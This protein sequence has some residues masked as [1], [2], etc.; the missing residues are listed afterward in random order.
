MKVDSVA[1]QLNS[2]KNVVDGLATDLDQAKHDIDRLKPA[3]AELSG[4][5]VVLESRA[6]TNLARE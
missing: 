6:S 5:V 1:R 4:R 3:L 2:V